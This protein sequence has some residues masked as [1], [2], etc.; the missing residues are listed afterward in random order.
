MLTSAAG[1]SFIAKLK[2]RGERTAPCGVPLDRA[3]MGANLLHFRILLC[4][5][6]RRTG[7]GKLKL[8]VG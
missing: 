7:G 2:M 3:D 4:P 5:L 1:T 8:E 6:S